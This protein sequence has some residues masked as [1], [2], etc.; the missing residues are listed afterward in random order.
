MRRVCNVNVMQTHAMHTF[1]LLMWV[2]TCTMSSA[3]MKAHECVILNLNSRGSP[4]PPLNEGTHCPWCNRKL[5]EL[6]HPT[7]LC[8]V[9]CPW[10]RKLMHD[11]KSV[12]SESLKTNGE[13]FAG[14]AEAN[15]STDAPGEST[16]KTCL[17]FSGY[18][19]TTATVVWVCYIL[20]PW[21]LTSGD[22]KSFCSSY[23]CW[24]LFCL[25]FN[26]FLHLL[27]S[28]F[29]C[30]ILNVPTWQ[31]LV[32]TYAMLVITVPTNDAVKVC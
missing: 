28:A 32:R 19:I 21:Q 22:N 17:V 8:L 1:W 3:S 5:R 2:F 16:L 13:A 26:F 10:S 11:G 29:S 6:I 14:E 4:S 18:H 30:H 15:Q 31:S 7:N 23:P 27:Q 9:Q 24:R 20:F 12:T 25:K